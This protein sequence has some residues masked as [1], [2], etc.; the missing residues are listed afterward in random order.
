MYFPLIFSLVWPK[1]SRF[2]NWQLN[3]VPA[4]GGVQK[5]TLPDDSENETDASQ[6]T[7]TGVFCDFPEWRPLQM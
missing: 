3:R 4:R 6:A 5:A 2:F 1:Q 7:G